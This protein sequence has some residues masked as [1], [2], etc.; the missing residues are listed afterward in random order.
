MYL[1]LVNLLDENYPGMVKQM[2]VI[3][4]LYNMMNVYLM[5]KRKNEI[6]S[7]VSVIFSIKS[8]TSHFPLAVE[9]C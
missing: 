4:G 8:S 7:I 5:K 3:N 9:Y 6:N 1:H 2:F